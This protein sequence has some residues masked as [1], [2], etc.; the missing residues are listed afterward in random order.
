MEP[1]LTQTAHGDEFIIKDADYYAT[2]ARLCFKRARLGKDNSAKVTLVRLGHA[3]EQ[4]A[5]SRL[6]DGPI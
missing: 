3:Y 5:W 4:R 6:R 2:K 1:H